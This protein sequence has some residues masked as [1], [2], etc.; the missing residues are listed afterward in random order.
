[1]GPIGIIGCL[2]SVIGAVIIIFHAPEDPEVQSVQELVAYMLKPVVVLVVII[3]I[4]KVVPRWGKT[5]PIVYL[6]ICSLVGSLSV[7]AIK[8]FGIA[9]KLTIAGNNQF[10]QPSTYIFGFMCIL[11]I[12]TQV[13][14]FNKALDLFS[15]NVVNPIYY[16]CFTTATIIASA[17][18]FQGWHTTSYTNTISLISGFMI[19]FSGVY[20]LD[21][22]AP[23]SNLKSCSLLELP[24]SVSSSYR[25]PSS[26]IAVNE[27][28]S[29]SWDD[30]STTDTED[31]LPPN[32]IRNSRPRAL[33]V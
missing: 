19:I 31:G 18:M 22:V 21:M 3:M 30:K 23:M 7:M 32:V 27:K 10:N 26:V 2:L 9:V 13:N 6:S 1:M 33:S 15:T 16:V 20:L 12:L 24:F 14:Y 11:F 28:T 8:A 29:S 25:G 5:S 4:W 17:I